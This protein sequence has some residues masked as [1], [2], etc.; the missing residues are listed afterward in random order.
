[1]SPKDQTLPL[2]ELHQMKSLDIS[3][4]QAPADV[5]A[6]KAPTALVFELPQAKG[7]ARI[8]S[9]SLGHSRSADQDVWQTNLP[10]H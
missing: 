10:T 7:G 9:T 6:A 3:C 1:M 4:A 5:E 2:A 8:L